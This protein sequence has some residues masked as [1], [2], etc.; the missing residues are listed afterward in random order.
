MVPFITILFS[1]LWLLLQLCTRECISSGLDD[2]VDAQPLRI[3]DV[4]LQRF[5]Q[6]MLANMKFIG[7]LFLRQ[8]L[9]VKVIGQ[10]MGHRHVTDKCFGL[11]LYLEIV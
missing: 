10:A 3:F 9:A 4:L 8:L 2:H 5:R 11:L 1:R 7:N 6:R